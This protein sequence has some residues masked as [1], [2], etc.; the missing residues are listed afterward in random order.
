MGRFAT[1]SQSI[2]AVPIAFYGFAFHKAAMAIRISAQQQLP[3]EALVIPSGPFSV[4]LS[5][6]LA[7]SVCACGSGLIRIICLPLGVASQL[8]SHSTIMLSYF[9][10]EHASLLLN[11]GSVFAAVSTVL[12][13]ALWIDLYSRL[14]PIRAVFCNAVSI[15]IAQTLI[16]FFEAIPIERLL[17]ALLIVPLLIAITYKVALNRASANPRDDLLNG[18]QNKENFLFPYK[19]VLFIAAYSFAYGVAAMSINMVHS[20]YASIIPSVIVIVL[21]LF[22]S[23]RVT[24]STLF[25]FAL[26]LMIVGFLLV[27]F[28]PNP[29]HPIAL[30]TLD[31]SYAAMEMLLLMMVCTIA[32]SAGAPALWLFGIMGGT[33][34]L[35]RQ[36]GSWL[37]EY[38]LSF[39]DGSLSTALNLIAIAAIIV[40]S[41]LIMSER[42]LFAF[43]LLNGE[44][45]QTEDCQNESVKIRINSLG[46][47]HGLTD[48]EM[49]VFYLMAQGK[50]NIEIAHDMFISEGTVKSHLHRI[51]QKFGLH[52]R[53]ELISLVK[54]GF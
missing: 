39:A 46:L 18:R 31:A 1:F 29:I 33:Q 51:Y 15:I 30:S 10:I 11:V 28:L 5:F 45:R 34:F 6:C 12:L 52:K 43:W 13:S 25:R 38:S 17:V 3:V 50:T 44:G 20:R 40:T 35:M 2:A 42:N 27:S 21:F 54:K 26:P 49:E 9:S 7:I 24:S 48:R 37:G 47:A 4:V 32:Y 16:F 36:I 23:R 8:L 41:F 53:K 22:Y 19:G 14:N